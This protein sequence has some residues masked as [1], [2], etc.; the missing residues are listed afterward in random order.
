L[1][2]RR[3]QAVL[4]RVVATGRRLA[5]DTEI[6][7]APFPHRYRVALELQDQSAVLSAGARPAIT[8]GAPSEFDGRDDWW[9]PEGLLLASLSLCVETTFQAFARRQGLPVLG[10]SSH[11][12]GVLDKTPAGLT[13]TSIRLDVELTVHPED[14]ERAEKLFETAKRHCIVSNSLKPP[15]SAAVRVIARP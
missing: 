6:M 7:T 2:D 14:V 15:V 8:G 11:A 12:E 1:R 4:D 10:W 13:F 3:R 9:S 5:K